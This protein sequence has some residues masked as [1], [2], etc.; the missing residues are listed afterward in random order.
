MMPSRVCAISRFRCGIECYF[1]ANKQDFSFDGLPTQSS[2]A[3]LGLVILG[4]FI[5]CNIEIARYYADA[6]PLEKSSV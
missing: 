3:A 2:E 5:Y 4:M 6:V 1:R